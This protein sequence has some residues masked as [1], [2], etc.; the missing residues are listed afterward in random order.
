M[1]DDKD[2][3]D[4]KSLRRENFSKKKNNRREY[5]EDYCASKEKSREFNKRK[6]ELEEED[7]ENWERFYNR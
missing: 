4:R 7:W 5:D 6:Q 2:Q 1:K 3:E